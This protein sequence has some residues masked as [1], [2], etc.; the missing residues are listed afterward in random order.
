MKGKSFTAV[1]LAALL[2]QGCVSTKNTPLLEGFRLE[3]VSYRIA[4]ARL[5]GLTEEIGDRSLLRKGQRYDAERLDWERA[6]IEKLVRGNGHADFEKKRIFFDVDTTLAN[7]RF[8]VQTII[9]PPE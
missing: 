2:T 7:H 3:S 8:A 9:R 4:D 5:T 6:R 1:F